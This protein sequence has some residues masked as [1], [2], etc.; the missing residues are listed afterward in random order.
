MLGAVSSGR[1]R[2]PLAALAAALVVLLPL[3]SPAGAAEPRAVLD[4]GD[5]LSVGT[6]P[7]LALQLRWYRIQRYCDV[8][9]R[10]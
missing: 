3:G 8:G 10:S 9:L 4:L 2:A 6:A 5:S 1:V 7:Y